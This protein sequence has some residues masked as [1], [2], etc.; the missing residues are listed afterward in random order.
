MPLQS[1]LWFLLSVTRVWR[2]RELHL[3]LIYF[4]AAIPEQRSSK[5]FRAMFVIAQ[6]ALQ[7]RSV[8][9]AKKNPISIPC[10]KCDGAKLFLYEKPS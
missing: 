5:Y 6:R 3:R 10:N 7:H 4:G 8:F 1:L 9:T 2:V